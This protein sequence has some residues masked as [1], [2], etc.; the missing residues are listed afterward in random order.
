MRRLAG[1]AKRA[2]ARLAAARR[3]GRKGGR[4]P[5]LTDDDIEAA[6]V[7]LANPDSGVTQIVHCVGVSL[8]TLYQYIPAA[9]SANTPGA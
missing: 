8:A 2:K 3:L 1:T 7:L 9:R 6:K 4:P 5:K